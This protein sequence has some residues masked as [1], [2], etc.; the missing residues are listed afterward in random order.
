MIERK[1]IEVTGTV[2]GKKVIFQ[3]GFLA[4]QANGA[5]LA[6]FGDTVALSTVLMSSEPKLDIDFFPLTVD[7]EEKSYAVG[8]IPGGFFKKEGRPTDME[9]LKARLIDRSIRPMFPDGMR[10]EVQVLNMILAAD[11]ENPPD[12]VALNGT[13]AALA[14]S[15][16][17]CLIPLLLK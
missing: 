17:P 11:M 2:A 14:V 9:I 5:V 4:L 8:K 16:I 1:K 12:I 15:D 10:N 6:R 7:Y 13:A 3:S